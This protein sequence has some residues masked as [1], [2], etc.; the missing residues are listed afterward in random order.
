MP[1]LSKQQLVD[2]DRLL[3]DSGCDGGLPCFAFEYAREIGILPEKQYAYEGIVFIFKKISIFKNQE[4]RIKFYSNNI[5][6]VKSYSV[7]EN[8]EAELTKAIK[9]IGPISV[10]IDA[11]HSSFQFYHSGI[12][13]NPNCKSDIDSL[14]HAVLVVGYGTDKITGEQYYIVKNRYFFIL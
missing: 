11:L 7:L 5:T 2:C 9:Q 10:A 13:F 14:N 4:C 12:Y 3:G 6:K 8:N 1:I